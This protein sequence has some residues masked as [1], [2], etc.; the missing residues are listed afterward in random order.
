MRKRG[1]IVDTAHDG[2]EAWTLARN[3][4]YAVLAADLLMPGLDGLRLIEK[5]TVL[6]RRPS[7]VLITGAARDRVDPQG[8]RKP[9]CRQRHQ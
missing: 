9:G 7:C 5:V 6:H 2:E 1:V 8:S 3:Y 4:P